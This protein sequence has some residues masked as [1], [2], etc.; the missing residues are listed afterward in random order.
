[1]ENYA[2]TFGES[3]RRDLEVWANG[4]FAGEKDSL[5]KSILDYLAGGNFVDRTNIPRPSDIEQFYSKQMISRI[6]NAQWKILQGP[7]KRVI[8]QKRMAVSITLIYYVLSGGL[9]K[10]WGLDQLNGSLYGITG[11]DITKASAGAWKVGKFNYTKEMAFEQ[12]QSW[13]SSNGTMSPYQDGA[14]WPGTWTLPVCDIDHHRWN[15]QFGDKPSRFGMLP[16]CCGPSCA[17]TKAFVMAANMKGFRTL[18]RGCKAQLEGTDL[19]FHAIDYGFKW[20][21]SIPLR[22]AMVNEDKEQERVLIIGI[23]AES[24]RVLTV[25]FAIACGNEDPFVVFLDVYFH[26]IEFLFGR[27]RD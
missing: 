16:C 20:N 12:L 1:M 2:A 8:I 15:T 10:P 7:T 22:W 24:F 18:L 9:D 17:D 3:A 25:V 26:L 23:L 21:N 5:N 4:T 6:I 11:K 19:D 14:G 27:E 13:A